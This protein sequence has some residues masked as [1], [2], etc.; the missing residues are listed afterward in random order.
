[1]N[2]NSYCIANWKMN[3]TKDSMS[4]FA[5]QLKHEK[6][7]N[8]NVK[9]IIC[10]AYVHLNELKDLLSGLDIE[11]GSQNAS[12]YESGAY[13]GEVSIDMLNEIGVEYVIVG[14]SERRHIFSESDGQINS[15]LNAV[16]KGGLKPILCIGET[17]E[18]RKNG[19]TNQVLQNQLSSAFSNINDLS[20]VSIIAYEPVWAIGSGIAADTET[21][22]ETHQSIRTLLEKLGI[23]S[24]SLSLIYGGSVTPKN[25]TEIFQ[26]EN[27]DGFLIG[28]ASLKAETFL[29]IYHQMV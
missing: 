4:I 20:A 17:I 2:R 16:I 25:C 8:I 23:Q 12:E 13:T 10:P 21:I 3:H 29:D 14:H 11:I 28:G 18:D 24:Q 19:K 6:K 27:V 15:K 9:Q 26:L 1:M 5:T 7:I 22:E